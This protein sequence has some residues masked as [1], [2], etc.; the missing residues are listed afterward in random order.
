MNNNTSLYDIAEGIN[1][2]EEF[3]EDEQALAEYLDSLTMQF[4]DKVSNVL[5]YRRT[6]E[7]TS[8][9]VSNEIDRLTQLKKYY[10]RKSQNLKNYVGS[11][12]QKIG[13]DNLELEIAKL[14]FRKSKTTDILDPLLIPSEYK[15]TKT[16]EVIDKTAIKIAI[17]SGSEVPGATITEHKNLQIK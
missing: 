7:L 11:S 5:R 12:M 16:T 10:E 15:L 14:S 2:V 9:A 17:E 3:I 4:E 6:L 13:K 8:E 1:K